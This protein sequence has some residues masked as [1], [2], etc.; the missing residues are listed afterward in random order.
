MHVT[1]YRVLGVPHMSTAD[2]V[3]DGYYLPKGTFIVPSIW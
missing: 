3:H 1:S 2:D